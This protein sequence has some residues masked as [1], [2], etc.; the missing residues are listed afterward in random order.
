MVLV[1]SQPYFQRYVAFHQQL[2]WIPLSTSSVT[3]SRFLCIKIID[4]N[5]KK[6]SYYDHPPTTNNFLCIYLLVISETQCI[7]SSAFSMVLS[8]ITVKRN[9][10]RGCFFYCGGRL[11]GGRRILSVSRSLWKNISHRM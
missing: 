6:F 2:H 1:S 10:A 5:V 7:Y 8:V 4:S 9:S 11:G 3:A